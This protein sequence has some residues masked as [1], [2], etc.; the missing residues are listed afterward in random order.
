MLLSHT[1]AY[2]YNYI[3]LDP[4]NLSNKIL[5]HKKFNV[6]IPSCL[7]DYIYI[8]VAL[9]HDTCLCGRF[10]IAYAIDITFKAQLKTSQYI[11]TQ[12]KTHT[13]FFLLNNCFVPYPK[14]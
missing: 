13:N 14:Q 8:V 5:N 2:H 7:L 11:T 3:I 12:M 1:Q 10:V 9:Q 4:N 6:F